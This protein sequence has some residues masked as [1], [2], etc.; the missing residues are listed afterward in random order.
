[1][2]WCGRAP[3]GIGIV[4]FHGSKVGISIRVCGQQLAEGGGVSR[5]GIL[6]AGGHIAHV[7]LLIAAYVGL[8]LGEILVLA[9]SCHLGG[10]GD[11]AAAA[12][13]GAV[14]LLL[15]WVRCRRVPDFHSIARGCR[16]LLGGDA[17]FIIVCVGEFHRLCSALIAALV[18]HMELSQIIDNIGIACVI[19]IDW[20]IV[21]F[22]RHT[23]ALSCLSSEAECSTVT[24]IEIPCTVILPGNSSAHCGGITGS[25]RLTRVASG[26]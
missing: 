14:V 11:K 2:D 7:V 6:I 25:R 22:S 1:M 5:C 15:G 24:I 18:D 10:K 13:E 17:D 4:H 20:L 12:G 19:I 26:A 9:K 21:G 8:D 23:H 16:N 3:I